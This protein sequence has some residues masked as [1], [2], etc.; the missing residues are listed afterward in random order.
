M[1]TNNSW[2]TP[3]QRSHNAIKQQILSKLRV[4]VPEVTDYTEGNILIVII[5]IFSAIAEVIHYYIDSTARETFF[6][7]ARRYSSLYK[8]AKLVDYHIKSGVP[9]STDL[10]LSFKDGNPAST[11]ISI[12]IGTEWTSKD[13]K[14]WINTKN[15]VWAS[16]LRAVTVP[17]VQKYLAKSNV[18]LGVVT[19]DGIAVQLS[20]IPPDQFYVE[21]SMSLTID[22]ETWTL[23]DTFAYY[24]PM[25]RVFKVEPNDSLIPTIY[26]GDGING[27]RPSINSR[28]IGSYYLTYG[29]ES[30]IEA[31]SFSQVPKSVQSKVSNRT[32]QVNQFKKASGG[33][34][35]E[36]F[37]TLKRRV[38]LSVKTLGVAITKE[39][40]ENLAMLQDGVLKA[41]ANYLCGRY[42]QI[43][44]IP[45]NYGVASNWLIEQVRNKLSASKVI[46]T[47]I[48]VYPVY[49]ANLRFSLEI[50]G[51]KSYSTLEIQKQVQEALLNKFSWENAELSNMVK[52][53]DVYA[54]IDNLP[55]VDYLNIKQMY[56]L[57]EPYLESDA[58]AEVSPDLEWRSWNLVNYGLKNYLKMQVRF[59]SST[60]YTLRV[61]KTAEIRDLETLYPEEL[62]TWYQNGG[63]TIS[64]TTAYVDFTWSL[65]STER[66]LGFYTEGPEGINWRLR[67]AFVLRTHS[68]GLAYNAGD[69]Y[70]FYVSDPSG[71]SNLSTVFESDG[72]VR[73]L[74]IFVNGSNDLRLDIHETL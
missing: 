12:P 46:T 23:V 41:Y 49:I 58:G 68:S 57:T 35:Y 14:V 17:V 43:F 30:N 31:D 42:V 38:P 71:N 67:F 26:F 4:N 72:K 73:Y 28:L 56:L 7:T 19:Y 64:D 27:M 22:G 10:I 53:S 40:F 20:N 66:Q 16:G 59:N 70:T 48:S 63:A 36:D 6:T 54:L 2:L 15:I 8:H 61:Y 18:V 51:N 1:P 69:I 3:Y 65:S 44:I 34:N 60:S 11:D 52:V 55:V 21:G 5:S 62:H 13:G 37:N 24:G 32:M 74:P 25:D 9:A 50:F 47:A 33:S 29:L 39:D 45:D